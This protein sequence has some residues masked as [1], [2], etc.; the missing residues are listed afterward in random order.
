M[1][2]IGRGW[3]VAWF[4][5]A[6]FAMVLGLGQRAN[7]QAEP[8]LEFGQ[9]EW[10]VRLHSET[11]T[12]LGSP[13]PQQLQIWYPATAQGEG[14]P[15]ATEGGPY[16][17]I[18]FQHAGGS[19]YTFYDYQFSRL[20]SR[21]MIV[22]SIRHDHTGCSGACHRELYNVTMD[23]MFQ[24]WNTDPG[25]WL[26]QRADV[27][28]IGLGG[29]SHGAAFGAMLDHRP[30]NPTG[31]Y[32]IDTVFLI[33]PCP[34]AQG[35]P[36]SE[37]LDAYENM[38]PLQLIYGSKDECGCTGT[39]QGIAMYEPASKPRHYAYVLGAS[40]WSFCEGG[41]VSH[42]TI[43]RLDAWR[44]S[45]AALAAFH[46][47]ML[48]GDESALPYLR[49]EQ[50]LVVGGPEVRYQFQEPDDF[51]ID[52][53]ED[54][55]STTIDQ[56]VA[57][58]GIPGQT[59]VNG[60]LGDTFVVVESGVQLVRNQ[61]Q[62]LLPLGGGPYDVLFYEDDA[63]AA[64]AYIEAV[65]REQAAGLFDTLVSTAS[66]THFESQLRAGPWD[67]VISA[68]QNG[69]RSATHPYDQELA[70]YVCGGGKAIIADFRVDS[71]TA[72]AT[73]ACAGAPFDGTTNWSMLR[74]TSMLF[75][76]TLGMRNPGWGIWTYGLEPANGSVVYAENELTVM[77][78][79]HN[80]TT[81]TLGFEVT[82]SGMVTFEEA[83]MLD[84]V[85][86]LYHP[87]WGL[88][89]AWARLGAEFT[90]ALTEPGGVGFDAR[91]WSDLTFR[92]L[93]VHNDP[94]NPTGQ[95]KNLTIR[96]TDTDGNTARRRLSDAVQ[97]SLRP[98]APPAA[99]VDRKSVLETY[100]FPLGA[101][102]DANPSLDLGRLE[103]IS[104]VCDQSPTGRCFIDDIA[105]A[106]PIRC[107]ADLDGDGSLT[108][109]DFLVFQNLFANSDPAAD[110][111][112]D[113]T[114]TFFDFLAF[115]DAFA[116]GCL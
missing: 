58:A 3:C 1:R 98:S 59:Y 54:S 48:C 74:S 49:N 9:H 108:V 62:D 37:Y 31:R 60:F 12:V 44:A 53:F 95:A 114:L 19:D 101:F 89:F 86:G 56:G 8:W 94:L 16:P 4:F 63:L 88:E 87:T 79:I 65:A 57:I 24:E 45:G 29:H 115:Q 84:A 5:V 109:F 27:Q 100:R 92:I 67:L 76:G 6:A 20:A 71:S 83:F 64:D 42:A 51:A 15:A 103:S 18:F 96:I 80:E 85:R 52:N 93:Q 116:T 68:Q 61:I 112:G 28:R 73:L 17:V 47:Y 77:G 82:S 36:I 66:A 102:V 105:L 70:D 69:S 72:N 99:T 39:G 32:D 22:V 34:I 106:V 50:P 11:K 90:H 25:H 111:D 78:E 30:M 41:S 104:F 33:A 40:H 81:S 75:E 97:G 2:G 35:V 7:A 23:Q 14:T 110:F 10:G 46:S 113:G 55:N 21:G 107:L 26:Y 43:S 38:P 13:F 91:G